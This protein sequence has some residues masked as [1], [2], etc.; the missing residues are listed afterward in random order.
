MQAFSLF[1]GMYCRVAKDYSSLDKLI[2]FNTFYYL[3][4]LAVTFFNIEV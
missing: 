2:K 3:L 1:Y 4:P